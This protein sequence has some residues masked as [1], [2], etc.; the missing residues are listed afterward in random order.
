MAF[1]L[2][3]VFIYCQT[4]LS[5]H[6]FSHI[7]QLLMRYFHYNLLHNIFQL[8]LWCGFT[9]GLFKTSVFYFA[10][11]G[12]FVKFLLFI[13]YYKFRY[14]HWGKLFYSVWDIALKFDEAYFM[15]QCTVNL[16]KCFIGSEKMCVVY[17]WHAALCVCQLQG[18]I[19]RSGWLMVHKAFMYLLMSFSA[20]SI[21]Y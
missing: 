9:C 20:S 15:A 17:S 12:D 10:K 13:F 7:H 4:F 11:H 1:L 3:S 2:S 19:V 16:S 5:K 8:L 14:F 18:E 21:I 6:S